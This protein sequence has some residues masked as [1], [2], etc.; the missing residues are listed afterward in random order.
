VLN[1]FTGPG[2]A[3]TPT[4]F[5][6]SGQSVLNHEISVRFFIGLRSDVWNWDPSN[7]R[8]G[9]KPPDPYIRFVRSCKFNPLR[10]MNSSTKLYFGYWIKFISR[11]PLA[12]GQQPPNAQFYTV[13]SATVSALYC[14]VNNACHV[15]ATENRAVIWFQ[16]S[17]LEYGARLTWLNWICVSFSRQRGAGGGSAVWRRVPSPYRSTLLHPRE[18]NK[19]FH[20]AVNTYRRILRGE[21]DPPIPYPVTTFPEN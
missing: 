2:V 1:T 21:S 15:D 16:K 14:F 11:E 17:L 13:R 6:F 18:P 9:S 7:L 5:L 10:S 4:H 12:P 20:R 8:Q 3:T 19:A